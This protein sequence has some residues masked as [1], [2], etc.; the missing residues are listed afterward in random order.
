LNKPIDMP[1]QTLRWFHWLVVILSIFLTLFAWYFSKKQID[2]KIE[3][4]FNRE[5]SQV[6][7]L[8][9]ER[10][11]KYEDG[12]WG[13]VA[14]IQAKGGDISYKDWFT[15]S[16]SLHIEVKYP[17]IN[18][19]GV[20]HHISKEG[21]PLYLK[22][23]RLD[24]PNY[25]IHPKHNEKE[26]FPITYI[27]PVKVNAKAVGLDMAHEINRY[28]AS[29]KARDTGVAQITGPI[30]LVQ[31]E[32]KTPGFLFFAPFY[33]GGVYSTLNERKNHFVGMVYAPFVMKKLMKGVL[34]KE[35]RRV[36]IRIKDG[37]EILYDELV[38]TNVDFDEHPL[39]EKTF[40]VDLYGRTWVFDIESAKSFRIVSK[41]NQPLMILFGGI[42]IDSLLLVL[43]VLLARSNKRAV[44]Y[45]KLIN[46]ELQEK[47]QHLEESNTSLAQAK[48][49]ADNANQAKSVFLAN[50]SHEIRTPMNAILGYTQILLRKSNLD[51]N[52]KQAIET[53]DASGNNLLNLINEILDISKIEAGRMELQ[54]IDFSVNSLI[55]GVSR[56]FDLPC[57]EKYLALKV[58]YPEELYLVNG[59]ENKIRQVLVNIIGNSVK[60]TDSGEIC[61]KVIPLDDSNFKF[62]ISDTG[63][64]ISD[65]IKKSIFEPFTQELKGTQKGGTGLGLAICKKQI[66]L[67]GGNLNFESKVGEGSKFYFTLYLPAA[68]GEVQERLDRR[69]VIQL[70]EGHSVKALIVDDVKENQDVLVGL[71]EDIGVEIELAN[72][73]KE[74]IEKAGEGY[75]IIFMDMK[76]PVMRGEEAVKKIRQ[77]YG[78]EE[79]KIVAITASVFENKSK[80]YLEMGC[81]QFISKPFRVEK[82]FNCLK[83]LL[84][85]EFEYAIENEEDE[86]SD[87]ESKINLP[88]ICIPQALYKEFMSAIEVANITILE[89]NL[90]KLGEINDDC[91]QVKEILDVFMNKFDMDGFKTTLD[92]LKVEK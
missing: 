25:K 90:N 92:K 36:G 16:N 32:A 13:G 57:R 22:E 51:K 17:G 5:A 58:Q 46:R 23:Q 29:K 14:A 30:A 78:K 41:N 49:D 2:E 65:D 43:F 73:G 8:I 50:M 74:A 64:G 11:K 68:I 56:M 1:V 44:I 40:E 86:I 24:R 9:S 87:I 42:V 88:E 85:V 28:T 66:E 60:F 39:F 19:I 26:F 12:L 59:D 76:M 71:L 84:G 37:D 7:E 27:E 15:F 34:K 20:I 91:R 70:A 81:D 31:D 83:Q 69:K 48:L 62:E 75:D 55:K 89:K 79:M 6:I 33:K 21:L 61:I 52:Q 72:N 47:T 35:K 80:I 3:N 10:M 67:M 18:G 82:I 4:Q 45:A 54:P 38:K 53:I 63:Y 77:K